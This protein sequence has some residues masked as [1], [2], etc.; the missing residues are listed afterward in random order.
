MPPTPRR[1]YRIKSTDNSLSVPGRV[2]F[3]KGTYVPNPTSNYLS[4]E[5]NRTVNYA[6]VRAAEL[7]GRDPYAMSTGTQAS[8]LSGVQGSPFAMAPVSTPGYNPNMRGRGFTPFKGVPSS[9]YQSQVAPSPYNADMRGR[10]YPFAPS[11]VY[12]TDD[13]WFSPTAP[14]ANPALA[15][16]MVQTPIGTGSE[17][18]MNTKFMQQNIANGTPFEKQLRWDP[19]RNKFVQIGKLINEGRLNVKTGRLGRKKRRGGDD[20]PAPVQMAQPA[21]VQPA[22]QYVQM[23]SIANAFVSFRA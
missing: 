12:G 11:S 18:F 14:A 13:S 9:F 2:T 4:G 20:E 10:G 19:D 8:G 22:Q 17:E 21:P 3:P 15:P 7:T 1:S 16:G 23:P 6:D 5:R